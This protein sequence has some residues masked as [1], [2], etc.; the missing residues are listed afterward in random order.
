[1][2]GNA[3]ETIVGAL[4]I[5]VAAAFLYVGY[6]AV[7]IG[8]G[9]GYVITARFDR[10]DGISVG[11]DVRISGIKVGTVSKLELDQKTYLAAVSI[12]MAPTVQIPEDSSVKITSE[13]LLGGSYLSLEPGGSEEY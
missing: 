11:S 5:A 2:Q 9:G 12:D 13:G 1:M 4:V 10:V 3:I 6:H 7:E 8:G